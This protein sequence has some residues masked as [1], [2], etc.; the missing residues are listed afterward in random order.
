MVN[1]SGLMKKRV[2]VYC[3]SSTAIEERYIDLAF[4]VGSAIA[5]AGWELVWGGGKIS[6][7]GAVAKGARSRGGNAIGVIP[8]KLKRIEFVDDEA[9]ELIEVADMRER[10]GKIESLAD[11]FIAL[12]GSLGTLEE[13][14][15]IWVGGYL[16]FHEKPIVIID[17]F[18]TYRSLHLLLDDLDQEKLMKPGQRGRVHWS[19]SVADS[20]DFLQGRL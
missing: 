12:P 2:A 18:D 16:N 15:E 9:S 14:F 11:A 6:M 8:T 1:Y 19:D 5:D 20:I 10:K 3:S 4:G 13:L 7:M 17:P